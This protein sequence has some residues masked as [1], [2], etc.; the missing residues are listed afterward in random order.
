MVDPSPFLSC[1]KIHHLLPRL[2][3]VD[4]LPP[5]VTS[6]KQ[7]SFAAKIC[8]LR[9]RSL[10]LRNLVSGTVK[11]AFVQEYGLS[12]V[13]MMRSISEART[14]TARPSESVAYR[15]RRTFRRTE[16]TAKSQFDDPGIVIKLTP[17]VRN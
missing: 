11:A 16:E 7:R 4:E 14:Q 1:E 9:G 10:A 6:S 8:L 17:E 13:R 5:H 3:T 2:G 15:K 12:F